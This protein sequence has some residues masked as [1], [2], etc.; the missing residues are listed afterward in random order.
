M[1]SAGH[2]SMV[3][4]WQVGG[5]EWNSVSGDMCAMFKEAPGSSGLRRAGGSM[6]VD[7]S[8]NALDA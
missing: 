3:L 6:N 2:V 5:R 4:I 8:V 7:G 1:G